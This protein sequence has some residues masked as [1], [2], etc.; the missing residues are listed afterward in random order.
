MEQSVIQIQ[1]KNRSSIHICKIREK[2]AWGICDFVN[3]NEQRLKAFFPKTLAQNLTPDLA[4][5]FTKL[6]VSQFEKKEEYLF[7]LKEEQTRKLIGLVYIK[8][9]DKVEGQGEFAYCIDYNYEGQGIVSIATLALVNY[10]FENL[11]LN[12]L[13]IIAH[14]DNVSS[15]KVAEK[16]DFIWQKTLLNGYKGMDMELYERFKN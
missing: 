5:I 4:E 9:L 10:A 14:K 7:T 3:A 1:S 15:I 12:R 2:D 13:Q 11:D 8:E 6:K 16:C